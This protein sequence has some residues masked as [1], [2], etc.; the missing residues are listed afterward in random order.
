MLSTHKGNYD[1]CNIF[2]ISIQVSTLV[3]I[4]CYAKIPHQW[5]SIYF[6]H[7]LGL[8]SINVLCRVEKI[9]PMKLRI[10]RELS[11]TNITY[12]FTFKENMAQ[13]GY[14][15]YCPQLAYLIARLDMCVYIYIKHIHEIS[16]HGIS[17][18]CSFQEIC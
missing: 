15:Y 6:S 12:S 9:E 14:W 17:Y 18:L 1:W 13:R 4:I 3:H 5:P 16:K 11:T 8:T 10:G 7:Y 2:I